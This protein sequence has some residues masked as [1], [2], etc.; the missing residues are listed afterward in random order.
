M[1]LQIVLIV[2]LAF[3]AR[4]A[5]LL[6]IR[7]AIVGE[8]G[9]VRRMVCADVLVPTAISVMVV[10]VQTIGMDQSVVSGVRRVLHATAE[11][12]AQKMERAYVITL[13]LI[14]I[15]PAVSKTGMVR[16]ALLTAV[17]ILPAPLMAY[18]ELVVPANAVKG[19]PVMTVPCV[20]ESTME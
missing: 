14:L 16:H 8:L 17:P 19:T 1:L 9:C 4:T 13:T 2:C 3:S 10:S 20:I 11:V 5:P 15:A 12:I 18:V 7:S 6:V